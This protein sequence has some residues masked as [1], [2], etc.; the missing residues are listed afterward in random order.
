MKRPGREGSRDAYPHLA[1][2]V[3]EYVYEKKWET[4]KDIQEAAVE[5]ILHGK[6]HVLIASGTASGKTEAAFFPILSLLAADP[7]ASVGVLYIGPLKALINDQFERLG[8]LF[9]RGDIPVLRWHGDI[10]GEH[11]KKLL[12][13]PRGI[14]QITP[15]SLEALLLKHPGKIIS[16][17]KDLRFVIID[18]VHAFMGS[19][20]GSQLLCQI[21][22]IEDVAGVRPR[23]LG[24][25]ATLGD[26]GEA[27][28]WLTLGTGGEAVLVRGEE[29]KRQI[30]LR[31]DY[32]GREDPESEGRYYRELYGQCRGKRC[33]IFTN[34]RLE[35]EETIARLRDLAG[36]YHEDDIFYVHHGSIS[37]SL[38][39]EAER[40]LREKEGPV[41]IAATATLELGLDIGNPDR[42]IHLG[43]PGS[44]SSFVQRLG[45]SGRRTGRPEIY[46]ICREDY[47]DGPREFRAVPWTLLKTIAVI[48]LYLK[49]QWIEGIPSKPLPYSLLCHQTL[50]FLMSRGESAPRDLARQVL[51]LPPFV[52]I[53]P[54][55]Y[56][57]LLRRLLALDYLEKTEKGG[58]IIG[59]EGEKTV[60]HYSFYSVFPDEQAYRVTHEGKELGEINFIPPEGTGL[61]LGGQYWQVQ[62]FDFRRR[63]IFVIPGEAGRERV[64]RGRRGE[65]HSRIAGRMREILAGGEAYPYLTE[66]GRI[67]LEEGREEARKLKL[68]EDC[69]ISPEKGRFPPGVFFL[70]PWLGSRALR[71][72]A[73]LFR[74][75]EI[76]ERLGIRSCF[77]EKEQIFRISSELSVP[78]FR[79][80]LNRLFDQGIPPEFAAGDVPLTD[81]YDYLL[82]LEL[83]K[84][85]YV[86]NMLDMEELKVL[87]RQRSIPGRK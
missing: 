24:L 79:K 35:A 81:K 5:A 46:F 44:V 50:S 61:V 68:T 56:R 17:F 87:S 21:G 39:D 22:R 84:K 7:P 13:K 40:G 69:F 71:T 59:L 64:W 72:L 62:G 76:R 49:E 63:E 37:P 12:D 70:V 38:R 25:S 1:P 74:L 26:Y 30:R 32:C 16:L 78:E 18:E 58:L 45:R 82:P 48:D 80:G 27:L 19:D 15:E 67:R 66:E 53:P 36:Q 20:R 54:E 83:L 75:R 47:G 10:P 73:A 11:K 3:R 29:P 9:L 55:D 14:L 52:E 60:N 34:S 65:T 8:P 51:S 6:S 42:I 33:I 31:L 85:Q 57:E 86:R 43:P 41:V 23:R 77:R 2:F 28:R 4:L